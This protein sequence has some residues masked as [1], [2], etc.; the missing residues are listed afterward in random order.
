MGLEIDSEKGL[1]NNLILNNQY[2][3]ILHRLPRYS[4]LIIRR[5]QDDLQRLTTLPSHPSTHCGTTVTTSPYHLYFDLSIM[6][7]R[8]QTRLG[9]S[10]FTHRHLYPSTPLPPSLPISYFPFAISKFTFSQPT[11]RIHDH[12][13]RTL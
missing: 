2:L 3:P 8:Q 6:L 7:A 12:E 11:P 9:G 4:H 5:Y 10:L 13:Q 1:D